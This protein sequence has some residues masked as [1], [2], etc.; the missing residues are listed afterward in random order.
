MNRL[1]QLFYLCSAYH[2]IQPTSDATKIY[3]CQNSSK[4]ISRHRLFDQVIDCRKGDD[5]LPELSCYSRNKDTRF[6]CTI[7]KKV[8]CLKLDRLNDGKVDCDDGS[9]EPND[10]NSNLARRNI[11]PKLCDGYLDLKP[12]LLNGE[13]MT[14][15]S[16]C[17]EFP[18]N[19]SYTR[20]DG[21]W[22]CPD[23]ADEVNCEQPAMCPQ[24]HHLCISKTSGDL[25]CLSIRKVNDGI[26]DCE[27]GI[28]E[29]QLCRQQCPPHVNCGY[30][31]QNTNKC[32]SSY[33]ACFNPPTCPF[34]NGTQPKFCERLRQPIMHICQSKNLSIA[35]QIVCNLG[36]VHDQ[37]EV[38]LPFNGR[39]Q[40]LVATYRKFLL[41]KSSR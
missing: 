8:V 5:E 2:Q 7:D 18:C 20:C 34:Q 39:V 27:G 31:C 41:L 25:T 24:L 16:Q 3:R 9:D 19:N 10:P 21:L 17:N 36:K 15:E 6:T 29:R 40:T 11:F 22:N 4:V 12:I 32:I 14:D 33:F 23:G 13:N 1:H 28:D 38:Y 35:E 37:R 26:I 30:Y